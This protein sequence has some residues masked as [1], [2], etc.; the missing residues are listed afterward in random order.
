MHSVEIV[1]GVSAVV[2]LVVLVTGV[3]A[4]FANCLW[5]KFPGVGQ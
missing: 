1:L 5:R 2:S 3:T 4:V